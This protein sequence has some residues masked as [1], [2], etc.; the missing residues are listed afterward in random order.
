MIEENDL[1]EEKKLFYEIKAKEVIK[2]LIKH[3]M[4]GK[5]VPDNK[6]SDETQKNRINVVL[7]GEELGI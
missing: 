7:V 1:T 2:N 4:S 6:G 3:N 5:Y